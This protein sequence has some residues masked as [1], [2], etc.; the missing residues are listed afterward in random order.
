MQQLQQRG[1]NDFN[2]SEQD[3]SARWSQAELASCTNELLSILTLVLTLSVKMEKRS[4]EVRC[5]AGASR[6]RRSPIGFNFR[7]VIET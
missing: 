4:H 2:V 7:I 6:R 3:G 5:K 1:N